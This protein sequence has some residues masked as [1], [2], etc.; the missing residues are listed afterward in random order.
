MGKLILDKHTIEK[1]RI[2]SNGII[3][4]LWTAEYQRQHCLYGFRIYGI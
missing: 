4:I 3:K 2:V 1:E